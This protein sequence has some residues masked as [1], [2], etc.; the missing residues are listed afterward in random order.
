ML[1]L[2]FVNVKLEDE[3]V[4]SPHLISPADS[5]LFE[6][7]GILG[8]GGMGTVYLAQQ[9]YPLREVALKKVD[10]SDP[11]Y[12]SSLFQ[13]GMLTGLLEHPNI[14]PIYSITT[15]EQSGPEVVMKRVQ[16]R[17]L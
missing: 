7:K 9:R 2:E 14:I 12:T 5:N 8:K 1:Q 17:T 15:S 13:E 10:N 3:T 11:H 16:G 6:K 4:A